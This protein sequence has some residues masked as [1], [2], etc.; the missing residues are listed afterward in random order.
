MGNVVFCTGPAERDMKHAETGLVIGGLV[1]GG[2]CVNCGCTYPASALT[3]SAWRQVWMYMYIYSFICVHALSSGV[4]CRLDWLFARPLARTSNRLVSN[5]LVAI[6][7]PQTRSL[8]DAGIDSAWD[9]TVVFWLGVSRPGKT[10]R[11]SYVA[12]DI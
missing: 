4:T 11:F 8:Q 10:V 1:V 3:G 9:G 7:T 5:W 12:G 2:F 6:F